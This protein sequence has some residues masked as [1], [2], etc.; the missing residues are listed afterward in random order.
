MF[1]VT[2]PKSI[3]VFSF[4]YNFLLQQ[5]VEEE[6]VV[7]VVAPCSGC[8]HTAPLNDPTILEVADFAL[9]EYDRTSTDE[10]NLHIILRLIKAHSQVF[11]FCIAI[12]F[13][14]IFTYYHQPFTVYQCCFPCCLLLPLSCLY[15]TISVVI[16]YN[17]IHQVTQAKLFR[18]QRS[19]I[20]C[21]QD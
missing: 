11:F 15:L 12:H 19:A 4:L 1:A 3:V 5:N 17:K 20:E 6:L 21:N 16:T 14:T 13:H 18:L 9:K 10:D 8:P 2:F 7:P